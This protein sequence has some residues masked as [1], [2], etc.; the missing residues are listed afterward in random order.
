M[1][2]R[3]H[4]LKNSSMSLRS[5]TIARRGDWSLEMSVSELNRGQNENECELGYTYL[6]F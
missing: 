2:L 6:G 1:L 5:K 4:H 3:S